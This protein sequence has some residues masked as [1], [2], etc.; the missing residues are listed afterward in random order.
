MPRCGTAASKSKWSMSP[1]SGLP[2]LDEPNLPRA[3]Q[4][5]KEHTRPWS[6]KG[7]GVHTCHPG[8]QPPDSGKPSNVCSLR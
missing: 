3:A 8:R 4:Y 6:V 5:T 7:D 2:L 1:G